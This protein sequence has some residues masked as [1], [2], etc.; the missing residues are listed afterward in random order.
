MNKKRGR[1]P[2]IT[3][4]GTYDIDRRDL[5]N[6]E[7]IIKK[8]IKSVDYFVEIGKPKGMPP[9]REINFSSVKDIPR[10]NKVIRHLKIRTKSP[11]LSV[12]FSSHSTLVTAQRVYSKGERLK[13]I[14]DTI[15]EIEKYFL[16]VSTNGKQR[17]GSLFRRLLKNRVHL[18]EQ[19]TQ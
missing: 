19:R 15:A 13:S 7:K 8:R 14:N 10:N 11:N 2:I 16:Q 1:R 4:L 5:I 6:I 9:Y 18:I 17:G 12:T 3:E